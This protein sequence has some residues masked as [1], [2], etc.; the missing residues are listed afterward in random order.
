M[1]EKKSEEITY[2]PTYREIL[3]GV[4]MNGYI[5]TT[6]KRAAVETILLLVAGG[7]FLSSY[8]RQQDKNSLFF[9]GLCLLLIAVLWIVPECAMRYRAR[10][11]DEGKEIRVCMTE[12]GFIRRFPMGDEVLFPLDGSLTAREKKQVYWFCRRDGKELLVPLRGLP[13]AV[14]ESWEQRMQQAVAGE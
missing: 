4:R 13:P 14:R 3:L 12:Q 10:Q 5:Y 6:V 2:T 1:E 9:F 11:L 7:L 8:L